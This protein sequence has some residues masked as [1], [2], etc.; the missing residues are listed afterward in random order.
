MV[1]HQRRPLGRYGMLGEPGWGVTT[2]ELRTA[3]SLPDQAG[4][5]LAPQRA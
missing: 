2:D 5:A 3:V 4:A 1:E